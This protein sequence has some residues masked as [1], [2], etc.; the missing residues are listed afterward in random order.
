MEAPAFNCI[1]V[2]NPIPSVVVL[3]THLS[4]PRARS[5][6]VEQSSSTPEAGPVAQP[7]STIAC[8]THLQRS[9]QQATI[10]CHS[11]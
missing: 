10:G 8:E 2:I 11:C 4:L 9:G 5:Q 1:F 3:F 7:Q 6:T